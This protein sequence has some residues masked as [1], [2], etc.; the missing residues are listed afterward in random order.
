MAEMSTAGCVL[1]LIDESAAMASDFPDDG[2]TGPSTAPPG[3]PPV[4]GKASAPAA[5]V[6]NPNSKSIRLA[7]AVNAWIKRTSGH[8]AADIALVGYA[9]D[10]DGAADVTSRWGGGLA[11]RNWI[12]LPTVAAGPLRVEQRTR[13]LPPTAPGGATVQTIDFPIWLEPRTVGKA[14]QL[15]AWNRCSELLT[16]WASFG[17][18]GRRP[19]IVHLFASTSADGNPQ[20]VIEQ[21]RQH[22]SNPIV[23]QIHLRSSRSVSPTLYPSNIFYLPAGGQ[24]D[25]FKRC[26]PLP[27]EW[28]KE[29]QARKLSVQPQAVGMLFNARLADVAQALNLV[30]THLDGAT[31]AAE[32]SAVAAAPVV[33]V[34]PAPSP[35][36]PAPAPAAEATPEPPVEPTPV[37]IVPEPVTIEETPIEPVPDSPWTEPAEVE[38]TGPRAAVFLLDRSLADPYGSALNSPFSKLQERMNRSLGLLSKKPTGQ[39][40]VAMVTYAGDDSGSTEVR[41]EP[42]SAE[43]A[44]REWITDAELA[45]AAIRIEETVEERPNGIGGLMTIPIKKPIYVEAESAGQGSLAAAVQHAAKLIEGWS[46]QQGGAVRDAVVIHFTRAGWQA[47][48]ARSTTSDLAASGIPV[49]QY[50]VLLPDAPH[51]AVTYPVNTDALGLPELQAAFEV[52]SP[53]L[54]AATGEVSLPGIVVPDS[55]GLTVNADFDVLKDSLRLGLTV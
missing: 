53:L 47:E 5:V 46:Q 28:K 3:P 9:T 48:E 45:T 30:E 35:V 49:R 27:E 15:A 12:S 36:A 39:L 52:S 37:A 2:P 25:L 33:P 38:R 42:W 4:P 31:S 10:T 6:A 18:A 7:T 50:Y 40:H 21:L 51:S 14:A 1:F 55:R 19:V 41:T 23:L 26:S 17:A 8:S 11:G 54:G 16:E 32:P 44:G 34:V 29:L 24:K 20:R 13:R 43:Q 22:P